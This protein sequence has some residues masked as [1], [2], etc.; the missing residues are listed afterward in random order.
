MSEW[1]PADRERAYQ[2]WRS[3][4]G[5]RSLRRTAEAT[6]IPFGTIT[7]WSRSEG[8]MLRCQ[9][10]DDRARAVMRR[11]A[12]ARLDG[13]MDVLVDRLLDLSESGTPDDKVKLEATKHALNILGF[14]PVQRTITTTESAAPSLSRQDLR[15]LSLSDL[16]ALERGDDDR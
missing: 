15:S 5:K 8:W 14:T 11:H 3:I 7:D 16:L 4:R 1:T 6:G 9:A 13:E 10:E 12:E 2:E